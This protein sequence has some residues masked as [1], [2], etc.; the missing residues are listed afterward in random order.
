MDE[1]IKH[2]KQKYF[3]RCATP[4]E[5]D[6]LF[7][8]LEENPKE[9]RRFI[10][11]ENDYT[12][13]LLTGDFAPEEKVTEIM[14]RVKGEKEK[15]VRQLH[16][17]YKAAAIIALPLVLLLFIQ[18]F[19]L[20]N[21][22]TEITSLYKVIEHKEVLDHLPNRVSLTPPTPSVKTI[23]Y[24]VTSGVKGNVTLADG[25]EVWLNS[26]TQLK[27]PQHF[28]KNERVVELSGEAYFKV[29]PNKGSPMIIKTE[30]GYQ[31]EV[32]GTEFNLSTYND[33]SELKVTLLSGKVRVSHPIDKTSLEME[34][35][36]ELIISVPTRE[37]VSRKGV[38]SK[39]I[40]LSTDW[41]EGI[42][43]FDNT[44]MEEVIKKMERWYGVEIICDHT[45][46]EH[47]FT[48]EFDSESISQVLDFMKI[49]SSIG[50]RVKDK[51]YSLYSIK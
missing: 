31:V 50:Y 36:E 12:L 45:L 35:M 11:E 26:N 8:F 47:R 5:L 14:N 22:V 44:P 6:I 33:D 39:G 21:R 10:K 25:S 38:E 4:E 24:N 16:F 13:S 9:Y 17:S 2:I 29:V 20:S 1:H 49:S 42:L 3:E 18:N 30:S 23:E 32:L 46:S 34:R 40:R 51:R 19:R 43:L 28:S 7:T 41:K 27:V 15:R 48:G 37:I